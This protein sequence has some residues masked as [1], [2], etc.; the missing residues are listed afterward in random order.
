MPASDRIPSY[1][2]HKASGQAVVVLNGRSHY[3]GKYATPASNVAYDRVTSQWLAN[4]RR[5]PEV[6]THVPTTALDGR[7]AAVPARSGLTV[8]ELILAYWRF[9]EGYYVKGGRPTSEQDDIRGALR[10]VRQLYG[11]TAA[12]DFGPLALKAIRQAMIDHPITTTTKIKDPQ[13][14]EVRQGV[15]VLRHG[16]TRKVINKQI[17]RVKRMFA[18]AVEEELVPASVH[19]ALQCVAGLR[20]GKSKA[21]EKPRVTP[22]PD[23]WVDA[24]LPV[25]PPTVGTMIEIQR[26]SGCRP[27]DIVQLRA[28]DI[29][30]T[31]PVW[32]Y[33]PPRYKTEHC[34]GDD[35]AD[36]ERVVFLGPKAQALLKPHLTLN[37]TD[38]LFSPKR[39]EE[40]RNAKRREERRTPQ[41]PSHMKR[42]TKG[43]ARAPIRDRY[44]VGTYRRAIARACL[45]AGVPVWQPNQLRHS[46]GTEIRRRYGLEASQAVLGHAELGVT[47]V[48]AEVDRDTAR[49]VIAEIG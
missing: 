48:Y 7:T 24:V 38:Y 21:R 26:L 13:T 14:G 49:R 9:A 18:W 8:N 3:L 6:A 20:K 33:R 23:T 12:N 34:S 46:R 25:V 17:S 40:A 2:L 15:K 31:G 22:V 19:R 35:S 27:Q 45:K 11:A 1:R 41:W 32:E 28:I 42:K 43:R 39:A 30:M 44:D 4:H 10:F 47:Q 36:R 37:V 5:L 16:L 29:D